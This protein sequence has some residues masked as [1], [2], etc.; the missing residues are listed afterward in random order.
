[1]ITSPEELAELVAF[2]AS[3]VNHAAKLACRI[4]QARLAMIVRMLKAQRRQIEAR[5]VLINKTIA[6]IIASSPS[7]AEKDSILRSMPGGWACPWFYSSGAVAGIG[8]LGGRKI[9]A[10]CGLAPFAR[11]SGKSKRPGRC[12]AGRGDIRSVLYMAAL[13][14]M[15][16]KNHPLTRFAERLKADS[17]P[18]KVAI[19]AV[20]RKMITILNA[21]LRKN[22]NW[23]DNMAKQTD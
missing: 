22:E 5:M 7:L 9:A 16:M 11:Q 17:K 23:K 15:R 20:M 21:M 12:Q 19:T 1:M 13:A 2:R 14:A 3:L 10:L 8:D 6:D 4:E 18:F